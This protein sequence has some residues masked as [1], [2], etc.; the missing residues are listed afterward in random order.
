M[1][2]SGVFGYFL[3]QF[4]EIILSN[5]CYLVLPLI[6]LD[7][8]NKKGTSSTGWGV[9]SEDSGSDLTFLLT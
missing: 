2:F 4:I 8:S 1:G 7:F 5:L 9:E 6:L 3:R